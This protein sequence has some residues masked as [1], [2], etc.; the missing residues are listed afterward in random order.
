MEAKEFS[1]TD[2]LMHKGDAE[3]H[4]HPDSVA[5]M[6]KVGW[7]VSEVAAGETKEVPAAVAPSPV[8]ARP[9][10]KPAH[11]PKRLP[12]TPAR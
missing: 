10:A 9:V 3:T 5:T 7:Q 8:P 11:A 2:V 6:E 4:V 1:E 12:G